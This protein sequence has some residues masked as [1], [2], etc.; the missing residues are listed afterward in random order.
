[1][2]RELTINLRYLARTYG[3]DHL[4]DA[5]VDVDPDTGELKLV[6]YGDKK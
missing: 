2:T 4:E 6:L 3:L 1:M 5:E